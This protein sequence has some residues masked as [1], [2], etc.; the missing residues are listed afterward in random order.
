MKI[1]YS[2]LLDILGDDAMDEYVKCIGRIEMVRDWNELP[3]LGVSVLSVAIYVILENPEPRRE[4]KEKYLQ[5]IRKKVG[6]IKTKFTK[7]SI[8]DFDDEWMK[9]YHPSVVKGRLGKY[10]KYF[11]RELDDDSLRNTIKDT[12]K[13][14]AYQK[15]VYVLNCAQGKKDEIEVIKEFLQEIEEIKDQLL[16]EYLIAIENSKRQLKGIKPTQ[17]DN[18]LKNILEQ[19]L[20]QICVPPSKVKRILPSAI[21]AIKKEILDL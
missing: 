4:I 18:R 6:E 21:K 20:I 7:E 16:P 1:T 17:I 12:Q 9:E 10:A 5:S 3:S 11:I 15:G 19:K 14:Y 2:D 13:K 8:K